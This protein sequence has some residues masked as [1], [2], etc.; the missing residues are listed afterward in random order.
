MTVARAA[1]WTPISN[2]KMKRGSN[3]IFTTAPNNTVIM[4]TVGKPW[5]V[6]KA[7]IPKLGKTKMVPTR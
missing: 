7:F 6:I 1:P 4:L 3:R 2:T 5:P